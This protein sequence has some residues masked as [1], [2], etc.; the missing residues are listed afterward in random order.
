[1]ATDDQGWA[2]WRGSW[3][4]AWRP[5][6]SGGCD[7]SVLPAGVFPEV[8][9]CARGARVPVHQDPL[10]RRHRARRQL[11]R[12]LL[13][14]RAG[15]GRLLRSRRGWRARHRENGATSSAPPPDLFSVP[16]GSALVDHSEPGGAGEH[17]R[18]RRRAPDRVDGRLHRSVRLGVSGAPDRVTR[19]GETGCDYLDVLAEPAANARCCA[20]AWQLWS[21]LGSL[22]FSTAW[23]A[24]AR[25]R[26]S[27]PSTFRGDAATGFRRPRRSRPVLC[28]TSAG[29]PTSST[30]RLRRRE[31]APARE[32]DRA[33]SPGRSHLRARPTRRLGRRERS[34][35]TD[36]AA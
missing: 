19:D 33:G 35:C 13:S 31:L 9:A 16:S 1:M 28:R 10:A 20:T 4:A 5:W 14:E 7:I 25:R 8:V 11:F 24:R 32:V 22:R 23:P 17:L 30:W 18:P 29:G 3:R 2:R 36:S 6:T 26:C 21:F 34:A 12:E 27:S 15:H